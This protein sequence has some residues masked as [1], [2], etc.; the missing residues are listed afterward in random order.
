M[1]TASTAS[2]FESS[3]FALESI[4]QSLENGETPLAEL[5][6]KFEEGAKLIENCRSQLADAE[7]KIEK[8]ESTICQVSKVDCSEWC[9]IASSLAP[10]YH[11]IYKRSACL[12]S[13]QSIHPST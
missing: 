7:L 2:T 9:R 5:V 3:M 11:S 13:K 10:I 12:C 4:I 8:I 1:K 6:T